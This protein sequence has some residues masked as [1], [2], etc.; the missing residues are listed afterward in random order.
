MGSN[1]MDNFIISKETLPSTYSTNQTKTNKKTTTV[2]LHI[3]IALGTVGEDE[4]SAYY[5]EFGQNIVLPH[6][7][8]V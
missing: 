7:R 3:F 5:P 4:L 1:K 8:W 6:R 2:F